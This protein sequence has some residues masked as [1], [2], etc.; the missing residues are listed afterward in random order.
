MLLKKKMGAKLYF[1][2]LFHSLWTMKVQ[3]SVA[4]HTSSD[5]LALTIELSYHLIN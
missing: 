2:P 4:V 3:H 5:I 1:H